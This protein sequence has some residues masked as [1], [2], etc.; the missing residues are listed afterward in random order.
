MNRYESAK[1]LY[2]GL[3]VDTDEALRKLGQV[4]ISMHCWQGDDVGGFENSGDLSGGIAATGN[5]PGKARTP[6]ELRADMDFALGF[7]P[8][9]K[10]TSTW[11]LR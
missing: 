7:V 10:K 4:K 6:E 3:G 5:Y 2:A 9:A 11:P 1:E 8:G